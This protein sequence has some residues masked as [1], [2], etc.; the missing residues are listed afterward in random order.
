MGWTTP[1]TW[2]A[3]TL[4]TTDMNTHVRDN[5]EALDVAQKITH[6]TV[7]SNSSTYSTSFIT[8]D[9]FSYT[10][11]SGTTYLAEA[12]WYGFTPG[13]SAGAIHTFSLDVN[14]TEYGSTRVQADG[15]TT[16][17]G[18][19][20]RG[21]VTGQ[22]GSQTLKVQVK[23]GGY[24]GHTVIASATAPIILTIRPVDVV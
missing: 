19:H 5:L 24:S 8:L 20:V 12:S 6:S 16:Q 13:N 17:G 9:S 2:T 4:T 18:G 22:S 3:T 15:T 11:V 7:T 23:A 14:G 21:I 10:F 1:K